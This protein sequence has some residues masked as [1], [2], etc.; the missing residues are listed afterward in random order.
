MALTPRQIFHRLDRLDKV[1]LR[2][3]ATMEL[4]L[5]QL[6]AM[7]ANTGFVQFKQPREPREFMPS[8][9]KFPPQEKPKRRTR[10]EQQRKAANIRAAF[11]TFW[12][13]ES[14]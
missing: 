1:R 4:M 7:V 6:I 11:N 5:G 14:P 2:N 8:L 12:E 3:E 9:L 10:K 13:P